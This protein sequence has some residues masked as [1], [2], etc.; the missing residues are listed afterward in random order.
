MSS[1]NS[2]KTIPRRSFLLSLRN[3]ALSLGALGVFPKTSWAFISAHASR[4][5]KTVVQVLTSGTTWVAPTGI[6]KILSVEC[7][8]GGGGAAGVNA[9]SSY[10][11]G[12]GGAYAK[13]LNIS[14]APG[15]SIT[16][17][18]GA[19]GT[20]PGT[21]TA[22]TD[23]GD[24][25]FINSTTVRAKGGKGSLVDDTNYAGAA[26]GASAS[27]IGDVVYSGG[28]GGGAPEGRCGSGGG[29]AATP[30]AAGVN[31]G[32]NTYAKGGNGGSANGG[33]AGGV[34]G[35]PSASPAVG[36]A[37]TANQKGG[38]GGGGGGARSSGA[39]NGAAGGAGAVPGGGAGSS[40]GNTNSANGPASSSGGAGQII[41]TYRV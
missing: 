31:G 20:S 38:G 18:I 16:Y 34:G 41:I 11:G 39:G 2:D 6:V 40:G 7:W 19:G 30:T 21:A 14:V 37:G 33:G 25:W 22:G 15:A 4:N 28:N 29:S 32:D 26:G 27:C 8:G 35:A 17:Q 9:G 1:D 10:G 36:A 5:R 24:T 13:K 12:G 3:M 23:G